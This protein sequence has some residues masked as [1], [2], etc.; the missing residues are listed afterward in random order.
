MFT[1]STSNEIIDAVPR[2]GNYKFQYPYWFQ[3]F[4][5]KCRSTVTLQSIGGFGLNLFNLTP[6]IRNP[7]SAT[8]GGCR[9]DW[10]G[11]WSDEWR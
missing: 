7:G 9:L 10:E 3:S 2:V 4:H 11:G 1:K 5:V 8:E 6:L